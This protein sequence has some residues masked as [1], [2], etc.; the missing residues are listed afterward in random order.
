LE[1]DRIRGAGV[2]AALS[3][4]QVIEIDRFVGLKSFIGNKDKF[5]SNPLFNF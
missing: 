4:T 1:S 2:S 5:I 3:V